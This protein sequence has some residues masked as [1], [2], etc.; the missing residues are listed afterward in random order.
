MRMDGNSKFGPSHKWAAFP[1]ISGRYN[2]S[3]EKF[4][5]SW[6][7]EVISLFGIRASWGI[8]GRDNLTPWQWLQIYTLD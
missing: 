7:P 5:R 8:T 6:L 3:D 4:V 1:G 2:I